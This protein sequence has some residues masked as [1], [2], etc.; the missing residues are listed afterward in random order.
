MV[1]KIE[2]KHKVLELRKGGLSYKEIRA[3]VPVSKSTL[4]N[5]ISRLELT[6]EEKS[7]LNSRILK[8]REI[9]RYK[10]GLTNTRKRI[11]RENF[12]INL[13]EAKFEKFKNDSRFLVGI[14]LYWAEG[15]KRSTEFQ[16]VNSDPDMI[17][18]MY[19]WIQKYLEI[20]QLKIRPRL[21]THRIKDYEEHLPFWANL[22]V[23]ESSSFEKTIF[24][25]T[26]HT[27]KKNPNYKGCLR[28]SV[29]GIYQLR[30]MKAWQKLL[31]AYYKM[32]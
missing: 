28:L 25:P 32:D 17:T 23:K 15:S 27:V 16:F 9:S 24:K 31:I 22:L 12:V 14:S 6:E 30:M 8:G 13:A 26:A 19:T 7:R 3:I 20:D 18:F 1:T 2:I 5:W 21:F 29:S 11:E 4:S 10:A